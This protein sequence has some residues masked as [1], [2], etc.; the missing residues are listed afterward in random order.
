MDGA[1]GG[2]GSCGS[3]SSTRRA[4][5]A[6]AARRAAPRAPTPRRDERKTRAKQVRAAQ[7]AA[8]VVWATR[9]EPSSLVLSGCCVKKWPRALAPDVVMRQQRAT[10]VSIIS[11]DRKKASEQTNE[12][13]RLPAGWGRREAPSFFFRLRPCSS[14]LAELVTALVAD[15]VVRDAQLAQRRAAR[16]R[17]RARQLSERAR[18]DRVE[19]DVE[20]LLARAHQP[21]ERRTPGHGGASTPISLLPHAHARACVNHDDG[22]SVCV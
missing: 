16:R 10:E 20:R 17:E 14:N 2:R 18:V 8:A 22:G 3:G 7:H 6:A 21:R 4:C 15:V 9:R 11:K 1:G 19:R 12:R 5:A 13:T